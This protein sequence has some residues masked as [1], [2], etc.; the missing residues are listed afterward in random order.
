MFILN[1]LWQGIE[2]L[3]KKI[4]EYLIVALAVYGG[5][6]YYD[7]HQ[8]EVHEK[9]EKATQTAKDQVKKEISGVINVSE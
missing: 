5:S 7:K 9:V 6:E 3:G 4:I 2:K 8:D 1:Y